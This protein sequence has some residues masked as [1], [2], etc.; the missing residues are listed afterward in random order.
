MCSIIAANK[1]KEL[2]LVF[3]ENG[4]RPKEPFRG[5]DIRR[6]GDV[7]GIYDFRAR[8]IACGYLSDQ[9]LQVELQTF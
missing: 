6:I 8:G 4:D 9:E 2:D 7:I 3:L 1:Q 5:N